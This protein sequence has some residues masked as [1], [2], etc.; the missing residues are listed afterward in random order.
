MWDSCRA[1]IANVLTRVRFSFEGRKFSPPRPSLLITGRWPP[2][3]DR[4]AKGVSMTVFK[5]VSGPE[6][7]GSRPPRLDHL[8]GSEAFFRVA[9]ASP[10]GIYIV[11]DGRFQYV[12]PEFRSV[13]GYGRMDL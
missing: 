10:I 2:V 13:T 3:H 6:R 5:S 12:N 4:A 11:Q 7:V 1:F 9:E 8:E